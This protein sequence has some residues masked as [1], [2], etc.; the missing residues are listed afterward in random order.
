LL[1]MTVPKVV[2]VRRSRFLP[3]FDAPKPGDAALF[4][5]FLRL[6]HSGDWS[7]RLSALRQVFHSFR[8]RDHD[9]GAALVKPSTRKNLP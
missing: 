8:R 6:S 7:S 3:H 4:T 9:P 5:A 2:A 1:E